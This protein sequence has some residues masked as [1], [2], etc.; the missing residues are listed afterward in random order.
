MPA[1]SMKRKRGEIADSE[2]DDGP[3]SDL[4]YGWDGDD[5]GIDREG[6]ME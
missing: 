5:D 4:E 6:L 1:T 3:A 2:S